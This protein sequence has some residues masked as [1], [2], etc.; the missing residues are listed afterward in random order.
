MR[1]DS[2]GSECSNMCGS[3]SFR[4]CCLNYVKKRSSG[5]EPSISGSG[6]RST[7]AMVGGG[8]KETL[9][10]EYRRNLRQQRMPLLLP[11]FF[12]DAGT[13]LESDG[14]IPPPRWLF[15]LFAAAAGTSSS[16]SRGASVSPELLAAAASN[17]LR[18]EDENGLLP[19]RQFHLL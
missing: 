10:A 14:G 2:C 9:P 6:Q 15:P 13:V 18:Y 5:G 1:C 16:T 12:M 3:R 17:S 19:R 11:P 7:L 4:L 8:E